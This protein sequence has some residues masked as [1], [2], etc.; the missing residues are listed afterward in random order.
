[1]SVELVGSQVNILLNKMYLRGDR[2]FSVHSPILETDL[3]DIELG[4]RS[5][6]CEPSHDREGFKDTVAEA[7]AKV[8]ERLEDEVPGYDSLR[9][10]LVASGAFEEWV[11]GSELM[12]ALDRMKANPG[13]YSI[14]LDT[15]VLYNRFVSSFLSE[16]FTEEL[17]HGPELVVS[18]LARD[19]VNEKRNRRYSNVE[20]T[21]FEELEGQYVLDSRE[22]KIA[23]SELDYIDEEMRV[24]YHGDEEFVDDNEERDVRIIKEYEDSNEET[25]R[26]GLVLSFEHS[27]KEKGEG[28]DVDVVFLQYPSRLMDV[29]IGHEDLYKV[30]V[31]SA[32]VFGVVELRGLGCEMYG[33]WDGMRDSDFEEGTVK[34]EGVGLGEVDVSDG[35]RGVL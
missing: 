18:E 4:R 3:F 29:E 21:V 31:Y 24:V 28:H 27:F 5:W 17:G 11:F 22:A 1:M 6:S 26:K 19:E 20:G 14:C 25:D 15:N 2:E 13:R 9:N 10:V 35:L 23:L 7:R 32:Q 8:P 16:R 33:V 34:V 12:Y 30:L